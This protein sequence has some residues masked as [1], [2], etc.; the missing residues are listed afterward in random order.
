M[1][2]ITRT[3]MDL[4]NKRIPN[5]SQMIM[6]QETAY[7]LISTRYN[8]RLHIFC[9]SF[10]IKFKEHISLEKDWQFIIHFQRL[11]A[12]SDSSLE[13]TDQDRKV[14]VELNTVEVLRSDNETADDAIELRAVE[15]NLELT[16]V[17]YFI[18]W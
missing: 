13:S 1:I 6:C 4:C 17:R 10:K 8:K 16:K 12:K 3:V 5:L 11:L 9:N 2:L 7:L 15:I 18:L 14:T